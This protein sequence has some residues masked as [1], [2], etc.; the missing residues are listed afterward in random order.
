MSEPATLPP[1]LPS[2][3]IVVDDD[4]FREIE[5]LIGDWVLDDPDKEPDDPLPSITDDSIS[6][7]LCGDPY[8]VTTPTGVMT[9]L[10][11]GQ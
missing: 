11:A 7:V 2:D 4:K 1:S 8:L 5:N 10:R 3:E 6:G 9:L